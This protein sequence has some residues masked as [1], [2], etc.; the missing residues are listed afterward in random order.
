MKNT[1]NEMSSVCITGAS[2]GLGA[3]I[4]QAYARRGWHVCLFGRDEERLRSCAEQC[5]S[6][7]ATKVT[8]HAVDVRDRAAMAEALIQCDEETPITLLIA[9]AGVSGGTAAQAEG[10]EDAAQVYDIFEINLNGV[11]NTITPILPRMAARGFGQVGLVSSLA[12][13][14]GLAGA[15]AY[16]ASK[17]AVRTYAEALRGAYYAKGIKVSA[18]CPGFVR[19]PL[20]DLNDF[21][22]PFL[23]EADDAAER[24]VNGLEANKPVIAFP[25]AMHWAVSIFSIVPPGLA[26]LILRR[27]PEKA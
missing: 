22:M 17:A 27:L 15:P 19:T 9:N 7:G 24:V 6:L 5:L 11:L 10:G 2:S 21:P 4:A 12:G 13:Y 14:R 3:A 1:S 20:T 8:V 23:L 18:I 25:W 16:S 26:G